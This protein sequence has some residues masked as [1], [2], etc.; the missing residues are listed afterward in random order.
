M[1]HMLSRGTCV[2]LAQAA[3]ESMAYTSTCKKMWIPL[4]I[5]H[6]TTFQRTCLGSI[7]PNHPGKVSALQASSWGCDSCE[8]SSVVPRGCK[9]TRFSRCRHL[10]SQMG[11]KQ[12]RCAEPPILPAAQTLPEQVLKAEDHGVRQTSGHIYAEF[13]AQ[14]LWESAFSFV[15]LTIIYVFSPSKVFQLMDTLRHG[16]ETLQNDPALLKVTSA[17]YRANCHGK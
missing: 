16:E 4:E 12:W 13:G 6:S 9:G 5:R 2:L 8:K 14:K 15:W 11:P 10:Y 17:T 1:T 7:E 3:S